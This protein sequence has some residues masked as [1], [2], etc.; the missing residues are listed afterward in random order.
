MIAINRY[1]QNSDWFA[2]I[3]RTR[4]S[5]ASTQEALYTSHQPD[6]RQCLIKCIQCSAPLQSVDSPIAFRLVLNP[7]PIAH[8]FSSVCTRL[9][10]HNP[11]APGAF[12]SF[13]KL[14]SISLNRS[15]PAAPAPPLEPPLF[16]STS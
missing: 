15:F 16:N 4:K 14:S 11:L 8:G 3:I 2:L 9:L 5:D 1:P 10:H 7:V 12:S 13:R 6:R